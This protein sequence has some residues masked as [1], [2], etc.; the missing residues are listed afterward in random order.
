[1]QIIHIS[2]TLFILDNETMKAI[3]KKNYGWLV[4]KDK[5]TRRIYIT[6]DPRKART[7]IKRYIVEH[8]PLDYF[9]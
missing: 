9:T 4:K 5:K 1:M 2:R 6:I 3:I 8:K 7:L